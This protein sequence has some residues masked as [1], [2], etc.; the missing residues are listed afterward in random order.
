MTNAFD[1]ASFAYDSSN[2]LHQTLDALG[3]RTNLTYDTGPVV[4]EADEPVMVEARPEPEER[5]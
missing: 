1:S 2:R 3:V 5:A 4:A